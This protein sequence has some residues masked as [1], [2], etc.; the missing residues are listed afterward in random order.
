MDNNAEFVHTVYQDIHSIQSKLDLTFLTRNSFHSGMIQ[1]VADLSKKYDLQSKTEF[2][3]TQN[4]GTQPYIDVLWL[5]DSI[6][7]VAFELNT[8]FRFRSVWTLKNFEAP[9]RNYVF[10]G[11][12]TPEQYMTLKAID[13]TNKI[14]IYE[15]PS[16]NRYLLRKEKKTSSIPAKMEKK[17]EYQSKLTPS[18]L[19]TLHL[20]RKDYSLSEIALHRDLA[21]STIVGHLV[22]IMEAGEYLDFDCWISPEKQE[23]IANASTMLNTTRLRPIKEFLGDDYSWDDIRLLLVQ[24][25]RYDLF[26]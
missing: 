21:E 13:D 26:E 10:F 5:L 24:K 4:N 14:N 1:K 16:F 19:E 15:Y 12:L 22:K 2:L 3:F 7:L 17:F 9:Y 6:P 25:E 8:S 18:L 23:V 20:F 11:K